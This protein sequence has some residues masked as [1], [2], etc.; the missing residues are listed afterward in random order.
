MT[1]TTEELTVDWKAGK[2]RDGLYY[3]LLE[4]QK[5]PTAELETWYKNN[6]E[7]S[8]E[9]Y[10]TEQVFYEYPNNIVREILAPV[11]T[12]EEY[13]AIQAELAEHRHYCC[14]TEN[15]VLRLKVESLRDLLKECIPYINDCV[16]VQMSVGHYPELEYDL[17]TRI[18]TAIGESEE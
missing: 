15:E 8:K 1:K 12:Y 11:P 16:D 7:D 18:N 4:N 3:I 14:C 9:Y 5:T 17:S 6:I 2:L 10:E 13:K